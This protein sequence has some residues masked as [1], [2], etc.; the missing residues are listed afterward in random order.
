VLDRLAAAVHQGG[1][2]SHE[3]AVQPGGHRACDGDRI[4]VDLLVE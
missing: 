3:A 1:S 4:E 2:D